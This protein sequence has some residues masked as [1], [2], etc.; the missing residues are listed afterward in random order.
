[1]IAEVLLTL[2]VGG[3]CWLA[4]EVVRAPL[5]DDDRPHDNGDRP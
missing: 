5:V 2:Y 4:W 1:M 3:L